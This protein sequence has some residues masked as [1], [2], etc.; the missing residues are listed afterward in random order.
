[1]CQHITSEQFVFGGENVA[2]VHGK[3]YILDNFR[4]G[5]QRTFTVLLILLLKLHVI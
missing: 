2:L 5:G 4:N 1:M 3:C